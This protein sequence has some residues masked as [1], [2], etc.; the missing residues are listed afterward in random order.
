MLGEYAGKNY[1]KHLNDSKDWVHVGKRDRYAKEK[2]KEDIYDAMESLEYEINTLH[3]TSGQTPFISLG[4]GLG[5]NWLEREIQRA[6]LKVRTKGLG[7]ERRSAIFP[8]IIF[9]L[10]DGLNLK[11][12]DPNYDIKQLALECQSKRV[13][14]DILNYDK[15][16][17][18]LG[19]F[20]SPM[21]CRS[22]PQALEGDN[23]LGREGRLNLGVN[24]LN[25]PR[26]ALENQGDIKGFWKL[27]D[28][29]AELMFDAMAYTIERVKE[30]T[31]EMAPIL[32]QEGVLGKRL[33]KDE[34]VD[35]VFK[36]KNATISF[37][38]IGLHETVAVYYGLDWQDNPEAKEFSLDIMKHIQAKIDKK[39][40][41]STYH[42][43]G[44]ST[45]SES[46][47]DRTCRLDREKFG[48]IEGI[49]DKD[50][51][52]NSFHMDVEKEISPFEKIDFEKDYL[53]YTGGGFINYVETVSLKN[54]LQALEALWDYSYDK[55][56]YFGVNQ[57]IDKCFE[58]NFEGEFDST[59][60]GFKCPD[61]GNQDPETCDVVKRLC[62]YL[63]NPQARPMIHGRHKEI[64]SRV[65]H[66]SED[67]EM[68]MEQKDKLKNQ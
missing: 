12:E 5:K 43:S 54:N 24:T 40:K 58:C 20:I 17:D 47:T 21:G 38:F 22:F 66:Q 13:Y 8:K 59:A 57:P 31:P 67:R 62:G 68:A 48:L 3:T 42:Y 50:F 51:Y 4:F 11:P 61:C 10:K 53:P 25:L 16:V 32:Y 1:E 9:T 33:K 34:E 49:T 39:N 46:L 44:Y 29:R 18:L 19:H 36:D 35:E 37:G 26:V 15:T 52:T 30:A 14:P 64:I 60:S 7:T 56:A 6:I 2:T 65:K 27:L 23:E 55:V 63:G 45:P 41:T 28:K